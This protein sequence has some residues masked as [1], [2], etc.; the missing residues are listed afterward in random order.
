MGASLDPNLSR[1][2][3]ALGDDTRLHILDALRRRNDQTLFE[4]CARLFDDHS[5][6]FTRQAITRH[7]NTLEEAGLIAT[8][9]RG[10]TKV[11]SLTAAALEHTL[12]PWLA[13][14]FKGDA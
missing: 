13:A 8:S 7:L 3:Q 6:C 12:H 2:F 14:F 1:I 5:I 9:W 4:I 10:R 11:H